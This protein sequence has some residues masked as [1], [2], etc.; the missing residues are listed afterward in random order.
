MLVELEDWLTATR[1]VAR[2]KNLYERRE[3]FEFLKAREQLLLMR[4]AVEVVPKRKGVPPQHLL[5]LSLRTAIR[6]I[7]LFSGLFELN[8]ITYTRSYF[9][10]LFT[11][12]LSIILSVSVSDGTLEDCNYAGPSSTAL[13]TCEDTL[14]RLAEKLPDAKPYVTVFEALHRNVAKGSQQ[15]SKKGSRGTT[16]TPSWTNRISGERHSNLEQAN[17]HLRSIQPSVI[18]HSDRSHQNGLGMSPRAALNMNMTGASWPPSND[19]N[20]DYP[21]IYGTSGFGQP[22]HMFSADMKSPDDY[23]TFP[24]AS[25]TEDNPLWSMDAGLGE[26]AYRDASLNLTLFQ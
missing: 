10:F 19:A 4:R 12:G 13:V 23:T 20:G 9:S 17:L 24:W 3:Y 22:D 7:E 25:L 6:G 2:P 14:R 15:K 18:S 21:G 1:V 16:I 5:P 11:A 26:Y 8:A